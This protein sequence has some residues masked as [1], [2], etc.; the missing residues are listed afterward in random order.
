MYVSLGVTSYNCMRIYNHLKMKVLVWPKYRSLTTPDVD[1]D[2]INRHPHSLLVGMPSSAATWGAH[3]KLN[4]LLPCDPAITLLDIYS[5]EL[6]ICVT[7]SPVHEC[8]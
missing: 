4:I 8:L 6:K 1:K 7:Q 3:A 2:A 5:N